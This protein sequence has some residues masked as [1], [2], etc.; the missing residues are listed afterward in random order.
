MAC[1]SLGGGPIGEAALSDESRRLQATLASMLGRMGGGSLM[2]SGRGDVLRCVRYGGSPFSCCLSRRPGGLR[3][4]APVM[5]SPGG[6]LWV[7]GEPWPVWPAGGGD[8]H[9]RRFPS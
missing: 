7:W 3:L 4:Q 6:V 1:G 5:V 2:E 9:G 8:A